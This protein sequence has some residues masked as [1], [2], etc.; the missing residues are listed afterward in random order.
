MGGTAGNA[1]TSRL[2]IVSTDVEPHPRPGKGWMGHPDRLD[3]TNPEDERVR[4]P[5]PR[6]YAGQ[7]GT[8]WKTG[9]SASRERPRL[10][11]S[12]HKSRVGREHPAQTVCRDSPR[13]RLRRHGLSSLLHQQQQAASPGQEYLVVSATWSVPYQQPLGCQQRSPAQRHGLNWIGRMRMTPSQVTRALPVF[14]VSDASK[15]S[16][17]ILCRR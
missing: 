9:L 4:S 6:S 7:N 16:S 13:G 1:G 11:G 14:P 2:L 15:I 5:S 8:R 10:W 17:G 3:S 12:P